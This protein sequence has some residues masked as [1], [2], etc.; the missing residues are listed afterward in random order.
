MLTEEKLPRCEFPV[1]GPDWSD[2]D[3]GEA[4][5]SRFSRDGGKTYY[6]VCKEHAAEVWAAEEARKAKGVPE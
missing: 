6:Y 5:T 1:C 2:K 4:V 3:C